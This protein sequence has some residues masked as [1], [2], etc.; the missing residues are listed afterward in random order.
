MVSWFLQNTFKTVGKFK[1]AIWKTPLSLKNQYNWKS[2]LSSLVYLKTSFNPSTI[3]P[4]NHT[5][6]SEITIS[7]TFPFITIFLTF[8]LFFLIFQL[9]QIRLSLP[10]PE[11]IF[12]KFL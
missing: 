11:K 9:P 6:L 12:P 10:K 5:S 3:S 1:K 4:Q 7:L 8:S 2:L